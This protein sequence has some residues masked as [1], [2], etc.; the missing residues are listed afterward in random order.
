MDST[1]LSRWAEAIKINRTSSRTKQNNIL[2]IW[3]WK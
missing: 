2:N 3:C 1:P